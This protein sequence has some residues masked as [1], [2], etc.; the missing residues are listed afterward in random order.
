MTGQNLHN[1]HAQWAM[2]DYTNFKGSELSDLSVYVVLILC[3]VHSIGNG[4]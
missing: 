1:E 2:H 4:Q 3:F